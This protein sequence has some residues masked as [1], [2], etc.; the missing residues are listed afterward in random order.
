M[1]SRPMLTAL[2]ASILGAAGAQADTIEVRVVGV[3]F[4]PDLIRA[5]VGDVIAFRNMPTHFVGSVDGMWPEAA[6]RMLSPIGAD[7][8]YPIEKEGLYVFKCPPHWGGARMGGVVVAGNPQDL[9]TT[10]ERYIQVAETVK[11]A[12]PAKSLLTRFRD[13]LAQR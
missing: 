8:N 9:G 1:F 13:A 4:V 2:A 5:S 3:K 12:K 10:V 6:P 7:Y 11:E